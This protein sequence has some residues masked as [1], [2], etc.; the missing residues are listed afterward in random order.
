MAEKHKTKL[1]LAFECGLYYYAYWMD[2]LP[3]PT[4]K[5]ADP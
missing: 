5:N 2:W 1:I 3:Y 4:L